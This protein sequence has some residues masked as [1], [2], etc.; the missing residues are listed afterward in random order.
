M[1]GAKPSA[2]DRISRFDKSERRIEKKMCSLKTGCE[3][4]AL[5]PNAAAAG[6]PC[7]GTLGCDV[8]ADFDG[9]CTLTYTQTTI[10][11]W[12]QQLDAARF[13]GYSDWRIPTLS[14]LESI[15]DVTATKPPVMDAAFH[16]ASCGASCIDVTDPACSCTGIATSAGAYWSASTDATYSYVASIMD[17]YFGLPGINGKTFY[18]AWVRAVRGPVIGPP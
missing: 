15:V 6:L 14:E 8:C 18:G 11:D 9:T 3:R 16:G 13:A 4:E 17:F 2:P 12:V 10:W 7:P 5:Q 1:V